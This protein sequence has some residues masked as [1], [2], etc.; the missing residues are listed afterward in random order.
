LIS[1]LDGSDSLKGGLK[2]KEKTNIQ[3][4]L[5]FKGPFKTGTEDMIQETEEHLYWYYI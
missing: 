2:E 4:R 1:A 3:V 5:G